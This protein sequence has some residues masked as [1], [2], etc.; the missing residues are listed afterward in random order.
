MKKIRPAVSYQKFLIESLRE[1]KEA[2]A[3]LNVALEPND[4]KLFLIALKNVLEAQ[5]GISQAARRTKIHRVSLCK[6]LSKNGNPGFENV[7]RLLQAAGICFQL[8]PKNFQK[9]HAA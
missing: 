4:P 1:P 5:G 8:A 3:Y 2:A 7:V 6:M 9:R